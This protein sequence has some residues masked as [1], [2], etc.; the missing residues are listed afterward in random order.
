[1]L[2]VIDDNN[3]LSACCHVKF[4]LY[5]HMQAMA[6]FYLSDTNLLMQQL[7]IYIYIHTLMQQSS[8]SRKGIAIY[9]WQHLK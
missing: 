4:L 9:L 5:L 2:D 8:I 6:L 1:M 3:F 7:P